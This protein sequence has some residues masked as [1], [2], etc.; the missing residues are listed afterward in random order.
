MAFMSI[1]IATRRKA[2]ASSFGRR[3]LGRLK[4][5]NQRLGRLIGEQFGYVGCGDRRITGP[6]QQRR[7]GKCDREQRNPCAIQVLS[8][9]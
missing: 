1:H 7:E 3:H 8:H 4:S 6:W 2:S 9:G 5:R